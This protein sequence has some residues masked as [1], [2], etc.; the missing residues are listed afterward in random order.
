MRTIKG[1]GFKGKLLTGKSY[2]LKQM[3]DFKRRSKGDKKIYWQARIDG[4]K[5]RN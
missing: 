4:I 3:Q 2:T 1:R 5:G